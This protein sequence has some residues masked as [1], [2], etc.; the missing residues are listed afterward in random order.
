MVEKRHGPDAWKPAD[1]SLGGWSASPPSGPFPLANPPLQPP[2]AL[3]PP[4]AYYCFSRFNATSVL[5]WSYHRDPATGTGELAVQT[6]PTLRQGWQRSPASH[7]AVFVSTWRHRLSAPGRKC[8]MLPAPA[9]H[10]LTA[11]PVTQA[12]VDEFR[13]LLTTCLQHAVDQGLQPAINVRREGCQEGSSWPFLDFL[14]RVDCCMCSKGT[15]K[16]VSRHVFLPAQGRPCSFLAANASPPSTCCLCVCQLHADDGRAENGWRNT[17]PFDPL[18][19]FQ[20]WGAPA[21]A[22]AQLMPGVRCLCCCA[23]QPLSAA[24][25]AP[26]VSSW[27][28]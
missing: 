15:R 22:H 2:R 16:S 18:Q 26:E 27:R 19:K 23:C 1:H 17:L 12:D 11:A 8:I 3:P 21:A 20:V 14:C 25:T 13:G 7:Q 10:P 9:L 4:S 28:R 6:S 24:A 5:W